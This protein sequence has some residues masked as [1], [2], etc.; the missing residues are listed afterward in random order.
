MSIEFNPDRITL[1]VGLGNPERRY[2]HTYHNVGRLITQELARDGRS[3]TFQR[4][5]HKHFVYHRGRSRTLVLPTTPMNASGIAVREALRHFHANPEGLLVAH[6]DADILF[7]TYKLSFNRGAA[8]HH[9]V[10]SIIE[11]IGTSAFWRLRVGTRSTRTDSSSRAKRPKAGDFALSHMGT[12][13]LSL[14]RALAG[15]LQARNA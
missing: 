15:Q 12:R 3:P 14:V 7:G 5:N 4:A 11:A 10:E 13:E 1:L 9:G 8:G 6:D 2:A